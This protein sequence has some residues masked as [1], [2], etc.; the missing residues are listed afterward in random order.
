MSRPGLCARGIALALVV[1][2]LSWAA[3]VA[4][5]PAA[6]C[7]FASDCHTP[8]F[9]ACCCPE[10]GPA[11]PVAPS[12]AQVIVPPTTTH[13]VVSPTVAD[14]SLTARAVRL[15]AVPP[16]EAAPHRDRLSFLATRLI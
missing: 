5:P 14:V 6:T 10:N 13:V 15:L 3:A 9:S 16:P 8:A 7:P 12:T 4:L 11:T 1:S 2:L